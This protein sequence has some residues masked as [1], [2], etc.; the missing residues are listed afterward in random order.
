MLRVLSASSRLRS[1][2]AACAIG[3]LPAVK[4]VIARPSTSSQK[5]SVTS[6][7]IVSR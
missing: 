7:R 1:T 5:P 2:I 4:P 6:A 3:W